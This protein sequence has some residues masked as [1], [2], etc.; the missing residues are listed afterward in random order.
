MSMQVLIV[1][2]EPLAQEI[3]Q[4]YIAKTPGLEL[5]ATC[6]NAL[7]AFGIL[8]KQ[9]VDLLFL[10]IN[11]PEVSGIDFLKSLKHP[12]LTIFTTAYSEFAL[13]G[14]DL[15]V[16]DYLLKPIPFDRFLKAAQKA[17][18][19]WQQGKEDSGNAIK[20]DEVSNVLFVR[21]EGKLVKIDL[22]QLWLI[23]GLKDYMKLWTGTTWIVVH[24]TMKNIEEQLAGKGNFIR[25]SKSYIVNINYVA[26]VDGNVIRINGQIVTIGTTYKD[27]VL[28]VFNKY[29]LL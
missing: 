19:V 23:E 26:E 16:I 8:S 7:E 13:M 29:K 21:A 24:S 27:E 18:N 10:D 1:D 15:D 3:L 28:G 14:Y 12:P 2:D 6:N 20:K 4:T 22:D 9:K 25:V 17:Q 11:M 5:A